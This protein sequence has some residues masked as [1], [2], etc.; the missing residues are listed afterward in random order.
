MSQV[1][2][3]SVPFAVFLKI[4]INK[5]DRIKSDKKEQFPR[6]FGARQNDKS[7]AQGMMVFH[8]LCA[9]LLRMLRLESSAL[10]CVV[11]KCVFILF[12]TFWKLNSDNDCFL[13]CVSI[14]PDR[15][16]YPQPD[17]CPEILTA[18]SQ[19]LTIT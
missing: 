1:V 13:K 17:L 5:V 12:C 19:Y 15:I 14:V 18:L 11:V 2:Q 9:G 3:T 6:L 10:F 8:L 4:A 7:T 16:M